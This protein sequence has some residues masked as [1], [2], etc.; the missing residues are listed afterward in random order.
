MLSGIISAQIFSTK[1][2]HKIWARFSAP[3]SAPRDSY[4]LH[5]S[6]GLPSAWF[7]LEKFR[8]KWSVG[9]AWQ[10]EIVLGYFEPFMILSQY[11][12]RDPKER[13]CHGGPSFESQWRIERSVW[14]VES[15]KVKRPARKWL[16]R[17]IVSFG[18]F[19]LPLRNQDYFHAIA[20]F[21]FRNP[22][23][24]VCLCNDEMPSLRGVTG[25][26]RERAKAV[27]ERPNCATLTALSSPKWASYTFSHLHLATF[28]IRGG[29]PES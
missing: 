16:H 7:G 29:F 5:K 24:D 26:K 10:K 1:F 13:F 28:G 18:G 25:P 11:F 12:S 2:E 3:I 9:A 4:T 8:I 19:D 22:W 17:L 21:P 20:S 14:S 15:Q 6:A 27:P 23:Y